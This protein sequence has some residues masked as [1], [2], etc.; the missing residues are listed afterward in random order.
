MK[1]TIDIG[2]IGD[3]DEKKSSHLATT[4]AIQHASEHLFIKARVTWLPTS[5]FLTEAGLKKSG[6][7]DAIWASPGSPYLSLEGAIEAIRL[8]RETG[9]PFIGT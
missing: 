4:E 5:S 7:F 1:K 6:R 3:Y 8:A 2:V 9:R